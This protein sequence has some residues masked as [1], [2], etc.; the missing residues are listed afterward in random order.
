[1]YSFSDVVSAHVYLLHL[2]KVDVLQQD[3]VKVRYASGWL[4]RTISLAF[5]TM[6][7]ESVEEMTM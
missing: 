2:E 1:M 5:P 3:S 4:R 6:C 7:N